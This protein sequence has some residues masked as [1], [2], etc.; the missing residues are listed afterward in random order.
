M[1][2]AEMAQSREGRWLLHEVT[3]KINEPGCAC[4]QK[5]GAIGKDCMK[6][7]IGDTFCVIHGHGYQLYYILCT[8]N[9]S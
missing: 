4:Q 7:F 5:K 1:P 9:I 3:V 8:Q 2:T 6:V